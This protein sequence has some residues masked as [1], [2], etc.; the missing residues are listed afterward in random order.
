M[1]S[2][3]RQVRDDLADLAR[4]DRGRQL[5]QIALRGIGSDDRGLTAGC[6]SDHGIAGCLF[7]HAYWQGVREGVF[8]DEGRPGDWIGGFVGAGDYGLVVQAIGSFDRLAKTGYAEVQ[9]RFVLPDRVCVRQP[10]WKA[11][12]EQI[13]VE[14]LA[15]SRPDEREES[16][17]EVGATRT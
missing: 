7:Q 9:P 1:T 6:W 10:E 13:L 15:D 3:E 17:L 14:T 8:A 11:A 12:V 5:L 16:R 2:E 4:S